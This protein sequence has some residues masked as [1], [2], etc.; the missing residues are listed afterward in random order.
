MKSTSPFLGPCIVILN[1]TSCN[2]SWQL[3]YKTATA[4]ESILAPQKSILF[5]IM[6]LSWYYIL[7]WMPF[8][9]QIWPLLMEFST[10]R[11]KSHAPVYMIYYGNI[12]SQ[13]Y[14]TL[15]SRCIWLR[16][17]KCFCMGHSLQSWR[18]LVMI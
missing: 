1:S 17:R 11:I 10:G 13:W 4:F 5:I 8:I 6:S 15:W 18:T 9:Q 2:L 12:C 3:Q 16:Y 7:N 14:I